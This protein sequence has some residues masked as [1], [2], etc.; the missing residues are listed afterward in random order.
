[1]SNSITTPTSRSLFLDSGALRPLVDQFICGLASQGHTVLTVRGYEDGARHFAAWLLQAGIAVANINNDTCAAFAAHHCRCP[2]GRRANRI[3]T[4]YAHRVHRF[5]QFLS[6]CGATGPTTPPKPTLVAP[7]V[8]LFQDWLRRHRG[9]SERTIDRYGR[10]VMRLVAT[11]GAEPASYEASLIRQAV[12]DEVKDTS[13]AYAKTITTALRCYLRF[14]GASGECRQ[15]L[16]HAVPTVP[17]WRLSALPRYL[18]LDDVERL[19][20]ACDTSKTSGIRDRAILLLLS[21]LGLR[22]GDV[23]GL[24]LD[25]ICWA[26]G[27]LRVSGKGRREVCLPL[28]QDAG[29]ALLDYIS[30]ARPTS[31]SDAVFLRSCAPYR[32]FAV[33]SSISSVVKL[34]LAR[35]GIS[36][37]PS[38]G[39]NLLRHSAATSMLRAGATLDTIGTV[40]RHRSATTTAHYAKVD[41]PMLLQ[42]VQPWPEQLSC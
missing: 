38:H 9:I 29:D 8:G 24:R 13:A 11:L 39:A 10:M 33:S 7:H 31:E 3:S 5:V 36:D 1:M 17:Q 21:R 35:A 42:V 25:H 30:H 18:P 23:L 15:E 4:K 40:L 14:L 22:G 34:A 37:P 2:G 26:D 12:L 27:T 32:P 20:G 41:I 16:I 28:P 6:A 19:I